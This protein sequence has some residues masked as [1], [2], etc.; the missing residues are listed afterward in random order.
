MSTEPGPE[1]STSSVARVGEGFHLVSSLSELKKS[2]RKR[3]AVGDRVVVVFHVAGQLYA[4]DYFCYRERNLLSSMSICFK[5]WH[6]SM[7]HWDGCGLSHDCRVHR[8][9][10]YRC[11]WTTWARR[12]WGTVLHTWGLIPIPVAWE[13]GYYTLH[14]T[15]TVGLEWD[16]IVILTIWTTSLWFCKRSLIFLT[17]LTWPSVCGVSVAQTHHHSGHRGESLHCHWPC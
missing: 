8:F 16:L 11:R 1:T 9:L 13:W 2:G 17:G 4:L 15:I 5:H 6:T 7:I 14:W 12:H 3:V 10:S